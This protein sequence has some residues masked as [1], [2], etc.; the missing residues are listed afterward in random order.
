MTT[1]SKL[2]VEMVASKLSNYLNC[3][4]EGDLTHSGVET[5]VSEFLEQLKE[6]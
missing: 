2:V 4:F 1:L 6:Q 5:A 3:E